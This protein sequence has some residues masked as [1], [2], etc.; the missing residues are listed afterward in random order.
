MFLIPQSALRPSPFGMANFFMDATK[1]QY[2][3]PDP[4]AFLPS[5][6][7]SIVRLGAQTIRREVSLNNLTTLYILRGRDYTSKSKVEKV[8]L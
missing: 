2:P 7:F 8:Y 4:A 5:F 6:F 3:K 1:S